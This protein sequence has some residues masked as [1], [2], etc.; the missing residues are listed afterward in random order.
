[1]TQKSYTTFWTTRQVV[2]KFQQATLL[3]ITVPCYF[4][5][6]ASLVTIYIASIDCE[7]YKKWKWL[8]PFL[9]TIGSTILGS[10]GIGIFWEL[11]AKRDFLDEILMRVG[12]QAHIDRCGLSVITADFREN[13]SW[14][15]L[16]LSSTEVSIFI[17]YGQTW[18]NNHSNII[19]TFLNDK[20]HTLNVYLP[21]LDSD[22]EAVQNMCRRF[23][24]KEDVLLERSRTA[25]KEFL[26][27]GEV[28]AGSPSARKR[29]RVN[30]I[31]VRTSGPL[32]TMYM[33]DKHAVI[34]MYSHRPRRVDVPAFVV[35]SDGLLYGF[36][37]DEFRFLS[38]QSVV[39]T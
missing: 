11:F 12:T 22:S 14:D 4:V 20:T 16:F 36:V 8:S 27:F 38:T 30:V 19:R 35:R 5:I 17:S 24:Y 23:G 9:N 34:A 37:E 25:E 39:R 32:H 7:L 31:R 10:M 1:M 6:L 13:I 26:A 21:E 29:G 3:G 2:R 15:D 28:S 33:F 18:R